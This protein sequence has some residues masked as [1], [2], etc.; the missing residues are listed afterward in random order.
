ML[1]PSGLGGRY[2]QDTGGKMMTSA[3]H[4][5]IKARPAPLVL[6]P[7]QTAVLVIDMQNDFGTSG[8]LFARAGIDI[9]PIQAAVGP[10]ANVVASARDAGAKVIYLKMEFR[11]DLSDLGGPDSANAIV[12][13]HFGVGESMTAP[14]GSEGRHLIRGTWNTEILEELKPHPEDIIVSKHRY[15]GFNQTDLDTILKTLDVKNLV[16]TGCTTSVCV[17]ST[18]R[19]AFFRDYR[20]ILLADCTAEPIGADLARS[21][22]DATL[23]VTELLFGWVSDSGSFVEAFEPLST[24]SA[25]STG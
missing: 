13:R 2:S 21:N 9:T 24:L 5:A 19:D 6:D 3:Y 22:H 17:E 18:L 15:S 7:Q 12:H 20:C 4:V 14:D 8:G 25:T 16:F 11:P 10:T 23:L 1:P